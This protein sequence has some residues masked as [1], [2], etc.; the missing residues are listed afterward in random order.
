[1]LE[2]DIGIV[3][4]LVVRVCHRRFRLLRWHAFKWRGRIIDLFQRLRDLH[5]VI[6]D[7][8][9]RS[10]LFGFFDDDFQ[11]AGCTNAINVG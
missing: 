5:H 7:A 1:M 9:L 2:R 10:V 3:A 11:S 8:V 6:L 4:G